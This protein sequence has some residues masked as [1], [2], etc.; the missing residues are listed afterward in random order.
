MT[1]IKETWY[2]DWEKDFPENYLQT[3][4]KT[5]L[6]ENLSFLEGFLQRQE[7]GLRYEVL[8]A[9][10]GHGKTTAL[11][12]FIKKMIQQKRSVGGLIV[13]REKTQMKEMEV[14]ASG[15]KNGILYIDNE[16]YQE[17]KG[18]IPKYQFVIISHERF[19]DITQNHST[20][21][22]FVHYE[23]WNQ[24]KRAI[25]IDEAPNFVESFI[26]ELGKEM[27][28]LNDCFK[29]NNSLLSSIDKVLIHSL[30]QSLLAFGF[31]GNGS[32]ITTALHRYAWNELVEKR[33]A[34]FFKF[35]DHHCAKISSSESLN[36]YQ[37]FKKLYYEDHVGYIDSESL[38]EEFSD[39]KIICSRRINYRELGC[40]ILI[41]DGTASF[42]KK[43]YNDEFQIYSLP[44][45]TKYE[46]MSIY[47]RR[48]NTSAHKRKN[49][50]R[51]VQHLIASDISK[52]RTEQ[53]IK[54][55]PLMNK[56]EV[57]EYVKL[58]SIDEEEYRK[59]F[60]VSL[61]EEQTLPINIL[62]TVGK[63]DLANQNSLYLTSLPNRPASYY[64]A[65][66]ISLY[67][68]DE[69]PL[70]LSTNKKN[71]KSKSWFVDERLEGVYQECLLAEVLQ[72][73]HRSNIRNLMM[74][75]HEKV[76]VFIATQHDEIVQRLA[77]AL[78]ERVLFERIDVE[79]LFT[80]RKKA[81]KEVAKIAAKIRRE[82][83]VLPKSVG[84]LEDGTVMKN[85][86]QKNWSNE[87]KRKEIRAIFQ[88]H[89]LD[90]IEIPTK[91]NAEKMEKRIIHYME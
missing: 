81:E 17:V 11:K 47:Q 77:E 78:G 33:F 24:K 50:S 64:Q 35:V 62:N 89:Q 16:N 45:H 12:I 22:S 69:V 4:N 15:F 38:R 10:P 39:Y 76:H 71:T 52:I 2:S 3:L 29:V 86:L 51:S 59:Y 55:F 37:W 27:T 58:G 82:K 42:T 84:R 88:Q 54:P 19:K 32:S 70:N 87:E 74:P 43:L 83:I 36:A 30:M 31:I 75:S 20:L 14:F 5:A 34:D 73:I 6:L 72:I 41:L 9:Q 56:F 79:N 21:N 49:L 53:G 28:W 63:N 40:S 48:I 66:A 18:Y 68:E 44:I 46:R 67:K 80:L 90:V 91:N 85:I 65:I 7:T 57:K 26:F 1:T 13:L 8:N 61:L 23:S 60:Q 25:I